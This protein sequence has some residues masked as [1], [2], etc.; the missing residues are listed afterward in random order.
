MKVES[1]W[2]RSATISAATAIGRER[3]RG[4]G[5]L[6]DAD[7]HE[8]QRQ[9]REVRLGRALRDHAAPGEEH[10]REHAG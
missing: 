1:K 3:G 10:E 9:H 6:G 2:K 5:P 4:A 7:E 8:R